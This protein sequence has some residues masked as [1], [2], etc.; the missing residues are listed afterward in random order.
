MILT[1]A[2]AALPPAFSLLNFSMVPLT[3]KS[4]T[5][6]RNDERCGRF[7]SSPEPSRRRGADWGRVRR[8]CL[9]RELEDGRLLVPRGLLLILG[10]DWGRCSI[11]LGDGDPGDAAVACVKRVS[12]V[13]ATEEGL[14]GLIPEDG[15]LIAR[16]CSSSSRRTVSN[17]VGSSGRRLLRNPHELHSIFLGSLFFFFACSPPN[18]SQSCACCVCLECLLPGEESFFG[19]SLASSRTFLPPR[20]CWTMKLRLPTP[21]RPS[22]A[23]RLQR[24][25][26]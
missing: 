22:H 11:F 23:S 24:A 20:C 17:S 19:D 6:C 25:H 1:F 10:A 9:G 8:W 3:A 15:E 4:S 16:S 2:E 14:Y 5:R 21:N 26:A 7:S 12:G 18:S 13:E